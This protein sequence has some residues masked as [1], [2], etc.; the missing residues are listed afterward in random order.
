M[1]TE[2]ALIVSAITAAAAAILALLAAFGLDLTGDQQTAILGV[3]TVL[4]PLVAGAITRGK[5]F[6]PASVEDL[7][8]G[9][10]EA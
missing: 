5:V 3:L 2:P 6:S 8:R 9:A 4:G 10:H 1:R 7:D